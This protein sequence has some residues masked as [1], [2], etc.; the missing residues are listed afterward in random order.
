ML[1]NVICSIYIYQTGYPSLHYT[2]TFVISSYKMLFSTVIK[3]TWLVRM[4]HC[5][6]LASQPPVWRYVA[7]QS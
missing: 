1:N 7:V 5:I 3:E 2:A 4:A 6:E